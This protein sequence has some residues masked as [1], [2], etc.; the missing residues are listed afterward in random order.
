MDPLIK[1]IIYC[2][3]VL[4]FGLF[5]WFLIKKLQNWSNQKLAPKITSDIRI[6]LQSSE[7]RKSATPEDIKKIRKSS[8]MKMGFVF[9]VLLGCESL[10]GITDGFSA[11]LL[12]S[13]V[14]T[15]LAFSIAF[16]ILLL[17][18]KRKMDSDYESVGLWIEKAYLL[19]VLAY[20]GYNLTIAYYDFINNEIK[21]QSIHIDSSDLGGRRIQTGDYIDI[22]VSAKKTGMKFN[23]VV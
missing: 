20:K 10:L 1:A 15:I 19:S 6:Y 4:L 11:F 18:D 9:I 22:M 7:N 3:I 16:G 12:L 23:C 17:I 5:I 2:I 13:F 14:V 8:A 21:I